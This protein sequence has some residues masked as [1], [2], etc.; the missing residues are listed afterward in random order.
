VQYSR[1][2]VAQFGMW[3]LPV[4]ALLHLQHLLAFLQQVLEWTNVHRLSALA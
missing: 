4:F 1:K 2:G 3:K